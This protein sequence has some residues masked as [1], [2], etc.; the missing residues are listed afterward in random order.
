MIESPKSLTAVIHINFHYR[1]TGA[2]ATKRGIEALS[3]LLDQS[4]ELSPEHLE[5]LIKLASRLAETSN[6]SD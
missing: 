6:K 3:K 5:L 4:L 1:E 2:E